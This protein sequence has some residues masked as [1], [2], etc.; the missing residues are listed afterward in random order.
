M[1]IE[2]ANSAIKSGGIAALISGAITTLFFLIYSRSTDADDTM[3]STFGDPWILFDIALV[4]ILA[5]FIFRKSRVAAILMFV[6]FLLSKIHMSITMQEINGVAFSLVFLFFFGQAIAGTFA[7]HRHEKAAHPE[8]YNRKSRKW[9][10]IILTPIILFFAFLFGVGA[11]TESGFGPSIEVE[12]GQ[13]LSDH[14]LQKLISAGLIDSRD[15]LHFFYSNGLLTVL[16]EGY[17]LTDDKVVEYYVNDG[18]AETY[19]IDLEDVTNV[20]IYEQGSAL[21]DSVYIVNSEKD[22]LYLYLS[23]ENDGDKK[24]I[25]KLK[26][27]SAELNSDNN[28]S[29]E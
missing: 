1:D 26:S 10:W 11:W 23:A 6:Y 16:S 15:D 21:A 18:E 29:P 20:E 25:E 27:L 24:F 5:F 12:S 22:S 19:S 7:Y 9:I 17:F 8:K 2:K 14:N 4:F 13:E 28:A 3:V